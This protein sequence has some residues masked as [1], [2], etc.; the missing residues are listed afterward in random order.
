M[1]SGNQPVKAVNYI[2]DLTLFWAV[3]DL[4]LNVEP[5][6]PEECYSATYKHNKA[7]KSPAVV[8][9]FKDSLKQNARDGGTV[10]NVHKSLEKFLSLIPAFLSNEDIQLT[11]V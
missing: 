1:I 9:I 6:V 5:V 2:C 4:P 8:Y 11:G 10:I 3:F 7:I